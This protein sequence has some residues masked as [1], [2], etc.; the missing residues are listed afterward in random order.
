MGRAYSMAAVLFASGK[1]GR[2]MLP[3]SELMLHEPLLGNRVGGN[4]SSLKSI[5]D[6][7]IQTKER[8]NRILAKH[9]GKTEEEIDEATRFDH[10][11]QADESMDFG[12]CD[13]IMTFAELMKEVS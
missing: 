8:L 5:S 1:H 12:L 11:F 6:T 3:N 2:Y 13:K 4:S 9:T 10:Y 7:L